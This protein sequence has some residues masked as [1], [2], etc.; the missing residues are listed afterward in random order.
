M[1]RYTPSFEQHHYQLTSS[2][3]KLTLTDKS[4]NIVSMDGISDEVHGS[5]FFSPFTGANISVFDLNLLDIQASYWALKDT[6]F[7]LLFSHVPSFFYSSSRPILPSFGY[8]IT[9]D[10]QEDLRRHLKIYSST[11]VTQVTLLIL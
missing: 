5:H 6:L 9:L 8:P 3:G 2:H 4:N 10:L 1:N 7:P 11:D